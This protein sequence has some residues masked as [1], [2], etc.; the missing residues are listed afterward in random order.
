VVWEAGGT[1]FG[2]A[3]STAAHAFEG[4]DLSI[5]SS[6]NEWFQSPVIAADASG[7]YIVAAETA[8][9]GNDSR[10]VGFARLRAA[11]VLNALAWVDGNPAP[12]RQ[13]DPSVAQRADGDF[14]VA[15]SGDGEDGNS[16]GLVAKAYSNR[17][18]T[19]GSKVILN[20]AAAGAQDEAALASASGGDLLAVWTGAASV[21]AAATV[22]ARRAGFTPLSFYTVQPCRLVDTRNPNGP[23]AGP[24]L[25]P[26]VARAFDVL[27]PSPVCGLPETARSLSLNVTVTGAVAPGNLVVGPGDGPPTGAN[28]VSYPAG[29]TRANNALR[30][31]ALNGD[32]TLSLMPETRT[33]V[34][35]D[36][37]GYFQ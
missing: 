15:W 16:L 24:I 21:G 2:R 35:I 32:G 14:V 30:N 1:I 6:A 33:H 8:G 17:G 10:K 18:V 12:T 29:S 26:G 5:L 25:E 37:N 20:A 22:N 9:K 23:L 11:T 36:V 31:V 19:I 3:F 13:K 4:S 27:L 34:I 28:T 7:N